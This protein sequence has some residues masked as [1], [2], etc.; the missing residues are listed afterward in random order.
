MTEQDGADGGGETV[1][2]PPLATLLVNVV[3]Q[4]GWVVVQVN[5]ITVQEL[6]TSKY[7][8]HLNGSLTR[9]M[10]ARLG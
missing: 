6:K 9:T 8:T 7:F 10:R 4:G 5:T 2:V 3:Q 1:G